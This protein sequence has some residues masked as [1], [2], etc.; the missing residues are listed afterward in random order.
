MYR[1]ALLC[2]FTLA[3]TGS[4]ASEQCE[5]AS[6]LQ[7]ALV[8]SSK[9]AVDVA[10]E[11][12]PAFDFPAEDEMQIEAKEPASDPLGAPFPKTPSGAALSLAQMIKEDAEARA[13][14]TSSGW[15][16]WMRRHAPFA[17][18]GTAPGEAAAFVPAPKQSHLALLMD[19]ISFVRRAN[20]KEPKVAEQP[21]GFYSLPAGVFLGAA[22][23]CL[24]LE[25]RKRG[26]EARL[27]AE[28]Q[29]KATSAA[30]WGAPVRES[31]SK[32][33][34]RAPRTTRRAYNLLTGTY[35][36]TAQTSASSPRPA[37]R[38]AIRG[39]PRVRARSSTGDG[40]RRAN[41]QETRSAPRAATL[42][43]HA[44]ARAI[45]GLV[46]TRAPEHERAID[47]LRAV[48]DVLAAAGGEQPL[49]LE[50]ADLLTR[51][52]TPQCFELLRAA[53]LRD[54]GRGLALA[55]ASGPRLLR[56][57]AA[58]E[59][60]LCAAPSKLAPLPPVVVSSGVYGTVG[61]EAVVY[62]YN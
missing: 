52:A 55:D 13:V 16:G 42:D 3:S 24:V 30:P 47:A 4:G 21:P 35:E 19:Q 12:Y 2:F 32:F 54:V 17:A 18:R 1:P 59:S 40:G 28:A 36:E 50:K 45:A 22:A 9:V 10:G 11:A 15:G 29:N 6:L 31:G 62:T 20:V 41:V 34:Q 7:S 58:V 44:D 37:T 48:R 43:S 46:F 56:A 60:A 57:L 39:N 23:I 51:G 14:T 26:A 61:A 38:E 33:Y 5:D 27:Q 53:G 49:R 8:Q 25:R